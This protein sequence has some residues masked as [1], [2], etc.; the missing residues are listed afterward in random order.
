MLKILIPTD[1]SNVAQHAID[2]T[3]Q[4]FGSDENYHIL[5]LNTFV[6]PA[7]HTSTLVSVED[8]MEKNA[9][10]HLQEEEDRI[11]NKFS[12]YNLKI[13]KIARLGFLNNI[14]QQE[15]ENNSIDYVIMGT[16]GAEGLKEYIL[17]SKAKS[18]VKTISHPILIIPEGSPVKP[19]NSVVFAK[20]NKKYKNM[21]IFN[22]LKHLLSKTN[23]TLDILNIQQNSEEE[24]N[25]NQDVKLIINGF[26]SNTHSFTSV[27][28]EAAIMQFVK[29][30]TS[31]LIVM[32]KRDYN[33]I[34][35]L[36][37]KSLT[38]KLTL[39]STTPILI[40]KDA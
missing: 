8:I 25:N 35:S 4:L 33:F 13:S 12:H 19:L 20:D 36:F 10:N 22:P 27:D 26:S 31:D 30:H 7:S 40:L 17:G 15:C 14:V 23:A 2:Y 18:V 6:L 9:L 3:L 29:Q 11:K 21:E 5:L 32:V 37:H 28:I 38:N 16:K 39:H 34:E 1:F 24:H